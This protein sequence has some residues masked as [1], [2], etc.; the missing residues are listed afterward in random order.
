M[1]HNRKLDSDPTSAITNVLSKVQPDEG[2]AS[3][4]LIRQ[5]SHAWSEQGRKVAQKM[6][7]GKSLQAA[8]SGG[9]GNLLTASWQSTKTDPMKEQRAPMITPMQQELIRVLEEKAGKP[10][11]DVNIRIIAASPIDR[12]AD[13]HLENIVNTFTQFTSPE[14]GNRFRRTGVSKGGSLISDFIFRHF[15]QGHQIVL[16]SEEINSIYHF[17]LPQTKTPN[18]TWLSAQQASA[19]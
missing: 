2:A 14:S 12:N 11:F 19:P 4:I 18:I 1:L 5:K 9:G 3:Q 10:A 7:E 16:T 6:Q 15:A 13:V 17:P 8:M